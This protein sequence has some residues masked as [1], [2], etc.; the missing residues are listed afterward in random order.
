MTKKAAAKKSA[1]K[2]D[3]KNLGMTVDKGGVVRPKKIEGAPTDYTVE[4][5]KQICD[6]IALHPI[7]YE[8]LR[9]LYP[10]I[11][12][13]DTIRKW[14]LRYPEF[15][16]KYFRVK[17]FQAELLVED[18]ENLLPSEI[19]YYHDKEGNERVD[20]P[21]AMMAI[22]KANNRKWMA[23]RLLP[24]VYGNEKELEEK[25]A[26]NEVL[27]KQLS[28]LQEKLLKANEKDY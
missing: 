28:E 3:K 16:E 5:G 14:R 18:I 20:S 19:I 21:S 27:K 11:P 23:A 25:T 26:E 13:L 2:T 6:L 22:A 7:S 9:A 10:D 17:Q 1:P 4:Y 12:S 15:A 8:K 24:R